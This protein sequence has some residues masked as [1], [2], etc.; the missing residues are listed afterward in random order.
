MNPITRAAVGKKSR[1]N[2]SSLYMYSQTPHNMTNNKNCMN[3]KDARSYSNKRERINWVGV[4]VKVNNK[5][6]NADNTQIIKLKDN[7]SKV[8][9]LS[10]SKSRKRLGNWYSKTAY[11]MS[12]SGQG[13]YSSH[14]N[15]NPLTGDHEANKPPLNHTSNYKRGSLSNTPIMKLEGSEGRKREVFNSTVKTDNVSANLWSLFTNQHTDFLNKKG[16]CYNNSAFPP[17][18]WLRKKKFGG[19]KK[20]KKKYRKSVISKG[21]HLGNTEY[22][23]NPN[24]PDSHH[25]FS[26]NNYFTDN[27]SCE[28]QNNP[29]FMSDCGVIPVSTDAQNYLVRPS[30][31]YNGYSS[32]FHCDTLYSQ[33]MRRVGSKT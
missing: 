33:Q 4:A 5:R 30:W 12:V 22:L 25:A 28:I 18:V 19:F 1:T 27:Q 17:T 13:R 23:N 9:D 3:R 14:G 31:K 15:R 8:I 26:S 10:D 6:V 29:T 11:Y 2:G 16:S 24:I 32:I 20:R 21:I 7:K